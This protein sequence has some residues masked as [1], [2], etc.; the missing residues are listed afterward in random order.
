VLKNLVQ[1]AFVR[2]GSFAGA[3]EVW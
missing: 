3:V 2:E 1:V